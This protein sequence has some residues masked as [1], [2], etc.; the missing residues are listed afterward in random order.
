[1]TFPLAILALILSPTR[2]ELPRDI[3][4]PAVFAANGS[5]FTLPKSQPIV[6]IVLM[7]ECPIA[8]RYAPVIQGIHKEF[9]R[10]LTVIRGYPMD[11]N[12]KKEVAAHTKDYKF[13]TPYFFDPTFA[14]AK[15]TGIRVSPEAVLLDAKRN[16][17]YRGRI[18]GR[19]IEH[20]KET[21]NFRHDLREAIQEHLAGKPISEPTTT[22]QGCFLAIGK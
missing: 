6:V 8:N 16:V 20:G 11:A 4:L 2:D 21:R 1:M 9:G 14:F 5:V 12:E 22:A 13:T 7:T 18:D 10:K 15:A 19:N 3:Q 17:I